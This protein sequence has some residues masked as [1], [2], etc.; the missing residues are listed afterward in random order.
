[1]DLV[2]SNF[3]LKQRD[4]QVEHDALYRMDSFLHHFHTLAASQFK[5]IHFEYINS[6][7]WLKGTYYLPTDEITI[8]DRS[9]PRINRI[10]YYQWT[11]LILCGMAV[12][13]VLPHHIWRALSHRNG[14]DI[15]NLNKLLNNDHIDE[16]KIEKIKKLIRAKLDLRYQLRKQRCTYRSVSMFFWLHPLTYFYFTTKLLYVANTLLQLMF[17]NAFL[18][19]HRDDLGLKTLVNIFQ[20]GENRFESPQFP[21][22]TMCDFMIRELGSN[23]HWYPSQCNLPINLYNEAIFLGIRL[24]LIALTILNMFWIVL[25]LVSLSFCNRKNSMK[26]YLQL[27]QNYES[28]TS[29]RQSK[30]I[31]LEKGF[32]EYINLDGF[33]VLRLIG[34]NT[35]EFVLIEII[36]YL[37]QNYLGNSDHSE[38]SNV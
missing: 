19:L 15:G 17:L 7:C 25:W 12:F 27:Y 37:Y 26:K 28:K 3:Q 6:I 14:L 2:Q 18:S 22:V 23:N 16:S 20:D 13:F 10:S 33:L 30:R 11:P 35:D 31:E 8:P 36:G 29:M 38:Q 9:K 32:I 34:H 21:R 5:E 4:S 1:M 24:W